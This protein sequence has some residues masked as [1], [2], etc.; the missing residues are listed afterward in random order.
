METYRARFGVRPITIEQLLAENLIQR[1]PPD[2]FGGVYYI[3][4]EGRVRSTA[5]E[6]RFNRPA[7]HEERVES[8]RHLRSMQSSPPP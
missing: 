4:G 6:R 1:I 5:S 2:P 7:T 3:D 8:I